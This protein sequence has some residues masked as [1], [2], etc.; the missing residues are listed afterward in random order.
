MKLTLRTL[1]KVT[2]ITLSLYVMSAFGATIFPAPPADSASTYYK[3]GESDDH[4]K[5]LYIGATREY[6]PF[7]TPNGDVL[8]RSM[9]VQ[10]IAHNGEAKGEQYE[11]VAI[12]DCDAQLVKIIVVWYRPREGAPGEPIFPNLSGENL[13]KAITNAVNA[14][15]VQNITP[16]TPIS[17]LVSVACKFVAP[18]SAVP[19][20]KLI[21]REWKT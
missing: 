20:E 2:S 21:V 5:T 15:P 8:I 16:D 17:L 11:Y 1:F 14:S 6:M 7:K 9:I 12:A 4:T 19:P 18:P 10:N 3:I 13:S